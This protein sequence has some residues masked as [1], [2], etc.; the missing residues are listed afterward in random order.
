MPPRRGKQRFAN[1]TEVIGK[2]GAQAPRGVAAAPASA[3]DA[4]PGAPPKRRAL[5]PLPGSRKACSGTPG[6]APSLSASPA[7]TTTAAV[8]DDATRP[9][10]IRIMTPTERA[11][12]DSRMLPQE[13]RPTS[14]PGAAPHRDSPSRVGTPMRLTP[15]QSPSK[16]SAASLTALTVSTSSERAE[17][18]SVPQ[19]EHPIEPL[20]YRERPAPTAAA[21]SAA[22][23]GHPQH[24]GPMKVPSPQATR[25]HSDRCRH[26]RSLATATAAAGSN[27][28]ATYKPYSLSS[29]K[30]L[31]ADVAARK[32]GGLGPSDTDEQ[33]AAREKRERAKTYARHAVKVARAALAG[34][35]SCADEGEVNPGTINIS[36][37]ERLIISAVVLV[38]RKHDSYDYHYY[39]HVRHAMLEPSSSATSPRQLSA[40][41]VNG[42]EVASSCSGAESTNAKSPK[43]VLPPLSAPPRTSPAVAA[44]AVAAAPRRQI[45][46]A[47]RR[48]ERALT[49]AREV[50]QKRR[51]PTPADFEGDNSACAASG[52]AKSRTGPVVKS[53]DTD[54]DDMWLG[55]TA[56]ISAPGAFRG[57]DMPDP[58]RAQRLQRLLE[59]EALHATKRE[60]W[61]LL[62][63]SQT[64]PCT[65]FGSV[66][67]AAASSSAPRK[68]SSSVALLKRNHGS[69]RGINAAVK[70]GAILMPGQAWRIKDAAAE[71]AVLEGLRLLLVGSSSPPSSSSATLT[72]TTIAMSLRGATVLPLS[73][74]GVFMSAR[75]KDPDERHHGSRDS[76]K[77]AAM[78]EALCSRI[79]TLGA[80]ILAITQSAMKEVEEL[81]MEHAEQQQRLA[82]RQSQRKSSP[83]PG[84]AAAK[85]SQPQSRV[86]RTCGH[87]PRC[88][89]PTGAAAASAADKNEKRAE[90]S[91]EEDS[92][93][94]TRS[95]LWRADAAVMELC[96]AAEANFQRALANRVSQG[97]RSL[98]P[99]V[100]GET[101]DDACAVWGDDDCDKGGQPRVPRHWRRGA[102]LYDLSNA[103][104]TS[105]Y[106]RC[107][108][109]AEVAKDVHDNGAQPSNTSSGARQRDD[110]SFVSPA[111]TAGGAIPLAARAPAAASQLSQQAEQEALAAL[112]IVP[113][114]R[115]DIVAAETSINGEVHVEADG[116]TSQQRQAWSSPCLAPER[117]YYNVVYIHELAHPRKLCGSGGS[118]DDAS[119]GSVRGQ[120]KGR[121]CAPQRRPTSRVLRRGAT[122]SST[123]ANKAGEAP[124][125]ITSYVQAMYAVNRTDAAVR[126]PPANPDMEATPLTTAA[127]ALMSGDTALVQL[128][129][130]VPAQRSGRNGSPRLE[131]APLMATGTKP[132]DV[133]F[134]SSTAD[135]VSD[136]KAGTAVA[137]TVSAAAQH[138][139]GTE[140]QRRSDRKVAA[141]STVAD[142]QIVARIESIED[143]RRDRHADVEER[144]RRRR[145]SS[146]VPAGWQGEYYYYANPG[147]AA[148]R[149]DEVGM[150][151]SFPASSPAH[152]DATATTGSSG[153][154]DMAATI[155]KND[156]HRGTPH[157]QQTQGH[158]SPRPLSRPCAVTSPSLRGKT[159]TCTVLL[160]TRPQLSKPLS[161]WSERKTGA[162]TDV[163]WKSNS[164]GAQ[165]H[166]PAQPLHRTTARAAL[167][168]PLEVVV[169]NTYN[170][171]EWAFGGAARRACTAAPD[172]AHGESPLA[173]ASLLWAAH[174]KREQDNEE[175]R[176]WN[177]RTRQPYGVDIHAP[178]DLRI[179]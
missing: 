136:S 54:E 121:T 178:I 84:K 52:G 130:C 140:T 157:Q 63:V 120:D 19:S 40:A 162:V 2:D 152:T 3:D 58:D 149:A 132:T 31:M 48:R 38:R 72:W 15:M 144:I 111:I 37:S 76:V 109:R 92:S 20:G 55:R 171:I 66:V 173:S 153:T 26:S 100:T 159:T 42:G 56:V 64:D 90:S 177:A 11:R 105:Q 143:W 107:V 142:A 126:K 151:T 119:L 33:R 154:A 127:P 21:A 61:C 59:L 29:Y 67:A 17:L 12:L 79:R 45:M 108:D 39:F 104:I 14:S 51:R 122:T 47:R 88:S 118:G 24:A 9:A 163:L 176:R 145:R 93:R 102:P 80:S 141:P 83:R 156:A 81:E 87:E 110:G 62:T 77:A 71:D 94:Y 175:Q 125:T 172:S 112:Y 57:A 123:A 4:A 74:D 75:S 146:V 98:R 82:K 135:R 78:R 8:K 22:S 96:A 117:S 131:G 106:G 134:S 128:E 7:P 147:G 16:A 158:P 6:T 169:T 103:A 114:Q 148:T 28:S 101:A 124:L 5:A 41:G 68:R 44:F 113:D 170:S 99:V 1:R 49:Y 18:L 133:K 23:S 161:S 160:R 69:S 25:H 89:A 46:Q 116:R 166:Q 73:D 139:E 53:G 36:P 155:E 85:P 86:R 150:P 27:K 168:P 34:V 10:R 30:T 165:A 50:S 43:S 129:L 35:G 164:S 179:S 65:A 32:S 60:A 97:Q 138:D 115:I 167:Y 70:R 174:Q 137:S 95:H 91:T 13:Q